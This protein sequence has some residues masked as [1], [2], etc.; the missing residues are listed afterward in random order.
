MTIT[1]VPGFLVVAGWLLVVLCIMAWSGPV[2]FL[3]I[4]VPHLNPWE[5]C[6]IV[7]FSIGVM[8]F[9][10]G[11]AMYEKQPQPPPQSVVV[12]P[13][14]QPHP[15]ALQGPKD[16]PPQV[17]PPRID[18]RREPVLLPVPDDV[19]DVAPLAPDEPAPPAPGALEHTRPSTGQLSPGRL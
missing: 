11:I 14:V 1:T 17:D 5:W 2:E 6:W 9:S 16:Q 7:L 3:G 15:W 10:C 19:P 13:A 8:S 12:Q 18:P 4:K